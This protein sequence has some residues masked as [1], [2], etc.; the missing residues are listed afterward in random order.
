LLPVLLIPLRLDRVLEVAQPL[1]DL[2]DVEPD[3]VSPLQIRNPP[4]CNETPDVAHTHTKP[5][6]ERRDVDQLW[7]ALRF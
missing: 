1:L 4:L 7:E 5:G 2:F 3:E 6:S